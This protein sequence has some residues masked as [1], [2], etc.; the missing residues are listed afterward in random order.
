MFIAPKSI[1]KDYRLMVAK[2]WDRKE[3]GVTPIGYWP[4]EIVV[5]VA[6]FCDYTKNRWIIHFKRM[7]F[8]AC[9]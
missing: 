8:M 6:Q 2:G 7:S 1:E 5:M 9:D 3:W 4:L